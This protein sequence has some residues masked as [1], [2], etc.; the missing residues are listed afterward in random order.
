MSASREQSA[1][2]G[3]GF[4]DRP[5]SLLVRI[6]LALALSLGFGV[7]LYLLLG[8]AFRFPLSAVTPALMQVHGQVQALGFV[9]L[10]I[11][12]VA[13]QLIPRFHTSTLDRPRLVS[14]GG[15]LVG[16]GVAL[17]A[18]AQPAEPSLIRGV[19]LVAGAVAEML[20]VLLA[21]SA[22]SR[23]VRHS[24]QPGPRGLRALLPATLASSLVMALALNVIVSLPLANGGVL[25]PLYQNE[26]LV[27]LELWGFASTMVFAVAGNVFPRFL[28]LRPT[29][30]R[31]IP[32][33]LVFWGIGSLGLPLV[34]LLLPEQPAA[35][36]T[37]AAAQLT[38]AL[39]Y[40]AAIRLYESAAR[41][42]GTPHVT[43]PTRT[44]A[45]VAFAFL[46]VAAA[47]NV[48]LPLYELAGGMISSVML[49]AVRH[50]LAQGFLLPVIVFM[51]AR[52]LPGYSGQMARQ[53]RL[54][55][56]LMWTLFV[57]AA[58][59]A[60]AELVGGYGPGW[61]LMVA[62]GGLLGVVAFTVFAIG[63]WRAIGM[64]RSPL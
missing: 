2:R 27:H 60:G 9:A 59:R 24:V 29:R 42:S 20:G 3:F 53:P 50:T 41:E 35:R 48:G 51:A 17:R 37:S 6:S 39:L 58:L 54:L 25:V 26:A 7:G 44:W 10:F 56:S 34:W 1:Q 62:L 32:P 19:A 22:F 4:L 14:V 18:V 57:G 55:G 63:L 5:F 64:S 36:I 11:I 38:G 40:L 16:T 52:I 13:A 46:L 45:R 23:V 61:S 28:L 30:E 21:I 8:F 31:L 33:A 12:A 43:N 15:L 49:S 47:L